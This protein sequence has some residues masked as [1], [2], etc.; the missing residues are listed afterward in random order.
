MNGLAPGESFIVAQPAG[1]Y[2][3]A[4][5]TA[6]SVSANLLA[7]NFTAIQGTLTSDYVLPTSASGP[8]TILAKSLTAS[9]VGDPTKAYDGTAVA[10]LT[11]ANF[12]LTGLVGN[13]SFTITQTTGVYDS[14]DTNADAVSTSLAPSQFLANGGAVAGDYTLPTSASGPGTIVPMT[15][16]AA[17]VGN[18]TKSYDGSPAAVL[19][20]ANFQLT[21]LVAGDGFTITDTAGAFN[22]KDTTANAVSAILSPNEF[23]AVG[24][25]LGKRL[26]VAADEPRPGP[27][28]VDAFPSRYRRGGDRRQPDQDV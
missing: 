13:D 8:G 14:K 19:T 9:I 15:L 16:T 10:T 23:I 7:G 17:I 1:A 28:S 12:Q 11:P 22:V 4:D 3:S 2:D 26:S 18:P 25:T 5:T 6:D 21:G 27:R 24:H 20:P